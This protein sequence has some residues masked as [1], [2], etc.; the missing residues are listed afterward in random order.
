MALVPMD[1]RS[2]STYNNSYAAKSSL[3]QKPVEEKPKLDVS[4]KGGISL[5]R[6]TPG[7]RSEKSGTEKRFKGED[8]A[9][10]A[11]FTPCF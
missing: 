4:I 1:D 10:M 7:Q 9:G 2:G 8:P 11:V 5:K 6:K 3:S